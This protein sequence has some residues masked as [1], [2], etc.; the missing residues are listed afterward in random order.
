MFPFIKALLLFVYNY[1]YTG[2]FSTFH[3][4][5]TKYDFLSFFVSIMVV[6][7]QLSHHIPIKYPS[8]STVRRELF[9][10]SS[11]STSTTAFSKCVSNYSNNMSPQIL[12]QLSTLPSQ[13]FV[14][15]S[16]K[17]C[18][19]ETQFVNAGHLF[20]GKYRLIT[21]KIKVTT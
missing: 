14:T 1:S 2:N 13:R 15:L 7:L 4:L 17:S 9:Q 10:T 12:Y 8:T 20:S 19:Q 6:F 18:N 21:C 3:V 16:D 5:T 11:T